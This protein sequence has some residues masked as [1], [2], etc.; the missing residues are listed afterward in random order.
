MCDTVPQHGL[1]QAEAVLQQR[2]S[3]RVV[4]LRLLQ[5]QGGVILRGYAFS[6]YAKQLAQH[7]AMDLLGLRV[8][9]NEIE[10]RQVPLAPDAWG[11]DPG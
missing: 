8:L 7:V 4:E 11:T 6:Y 2:L 1:E 10:V 3:R 5:R 9:V